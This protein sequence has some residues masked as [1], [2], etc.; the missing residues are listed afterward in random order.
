[1][2][3]YKKDLFYFFSFFI[4]I[5]NNSYSQ[6]NSPA[7]PSSSYNNE[8]F[9]KD[10]KLIENKPVVAP[11]NVQIVVQGNNRLDSSVNRIGID[12]NGLVLVLHDAHP[13]DSAYY[14]CRAENTI[15]NMNKQIILYLV[16]F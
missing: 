13:S 8:Y 15:T 3:K 12:L 2:S 14:R 11:K 9:N 4:L 5:T 16:T 7:S 1:M 10:E 6:D